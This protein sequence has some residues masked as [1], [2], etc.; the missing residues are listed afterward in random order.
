MTNN[1][2]IDLKLLRHF[3][4]TAETL[5]Y[6]EAA[7]ILNVTKSKLSKDIAKLEG[8]LGSKVFERSSR[9]VRLSETGKILYSR[10]LVLLE[11]SNHL[12][13][14]IKTLNSSVSGKLSLAAPPAL[15]RVLSNSLFPN[16]LKD[17]P[18]VSLSLKLSYEYENLFKEGLDLAFRMGKNQDENLIQRQI[19][20]ANRVLVASPNYLKHHAIKTVKDL[21]S[22]RSVQFFEPTQNTWTLQNGEKTEYASVPVAFQC[23]DF[24]AVLNCVKNHLGIAQLPW[25]LVRDGIKSGEL[26]QV[27]PAWVSPSLPIYMVYR[28]GFNKPNKLAEFLSYIEAHKSMFDLEFMSS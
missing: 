19:G 3:V 9:V 22:C 24:V 8:E 11:D 18:Q 21:T 1:Q 2:V 5:S 4:V 17:W 25:F 10:A 20:K 14:D 27:L 7:N 13:N 16:F 12:L 28:Q 6:T 15:G 26:R 23:A